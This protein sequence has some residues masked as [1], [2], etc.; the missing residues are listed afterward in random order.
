MKEDPNLITEDEYNNI[1]EKNICLVLK[2]ASD[3]DKLL[4]MKLDLKY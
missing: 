3:E 1:I 2:D 4:G